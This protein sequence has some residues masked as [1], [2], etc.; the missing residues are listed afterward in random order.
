MQEFLE[1]GTAMKGDELET[2]IVFSGVN[3]KAVHSFLTTECGMIEKA[4][5][6]AKRITDGAL[7]IDIYDSTCYRIKRRLKYFIYSYMEMYPLKFELSN[8]TS[9]KPVSNIHF[10]N[11]DDIITLFNF[12]FYKCLPTYQRIYTKSETICA[13]LIEMHKG[14]YNL[15]IELD[16]NPSETHHVE[17]VV[18]DID[19]YVKIVNLALN[20]V[21]SSA[22]K[23]LRKF[24]SPRVSNLPAPLKTKN[25]WIS[26]KWNGTRFHF[27]ILK[28]NVIFR[29]IG[30]EPSKI[31]DKSEGIS[32]LEKTYPLATLFLKNVG[33]NV[34]VLDDII[35]VYDTL[36]SN[37]VRNNIFCLMQLNRLIELLRMI[38]NI[39]IYSQMF[40]PVSTMTH[41]YDFPLNHL[42]RY[43]SK[44]DGLIITTNYKQYKIKPKY[45][46]T[47]DLFFNERKKM[48]TAE[49]L[50]LG[51]NLVWP[52]HIPQLENYVYECRLENVNWYLFHR[53]SNKE[54]RRLL[55]ESTVFIIRQRLDRGHQ[56]NG[57]KTILS[58]L[59]SQDIVNFAYSI[60]SCLKNCKV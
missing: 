55:Q 13:K 35:I 58:Y 32:F 48:S 52:Q 57:W 14:V 10:E 51:K 15:T 25:F 4:F 17:E 11:N 16:F 60:Q 36:V 56:A 20:K 59:E 18:D 7:S 30:F 2:R 47:V 12:C 5:R 19:M 27:S 31:I 49:G 9:L 38:L 28:P 1:R 54:K 37:K 44:T 23:Y 24:K 8:E 22:V 6:V 46:T 29:G 42:T 21:A 45:E 53:V 40:I 43:I 3:P 39:P 50:E 26:P 41:I 33:F 34:E